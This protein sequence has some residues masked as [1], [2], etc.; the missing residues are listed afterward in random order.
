MCEGTAPLFI[1]DPGLLPPYKTPLVRKILQKFSPRLDW[2]CCGSAMA[3]RMPTA[4]HRPSIYFF[5]A[6]N[7]LLVVI[8]VY[9]AENCGLGMFSAPLSSAPQPTFLVRR[10]ANPPLSR[11]IGVFKHGFDGFR[12]SP[13]ASDSLSQITAA[14]SG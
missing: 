9:Y 11:G 6:M 4:G 13:P 5:L 12:Y 8:V 7:T 2:C 14:F 3:R 1:A 10:R